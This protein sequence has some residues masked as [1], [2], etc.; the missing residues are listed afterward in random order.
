L[1]IPFAD[2]QN[3][4]LLIATILRI[5]KIKQSYEIEEVASF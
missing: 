4:F 2:L 3:I 1:N 5:L